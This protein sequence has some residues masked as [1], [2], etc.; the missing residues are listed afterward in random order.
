MREPSWSEAHP[1]LAKKI[2]E[3]ATPKHFP[4]C[5]P[6]E[7]VYNFMRDLGFRMSNWS[8]KHWERADGV[9]V[10]IYGAGSRARIYLK[11]QIATDCE[12][13]NLAQALN[14]EQRT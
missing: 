7:P 13:D 2:R 10:Q 6:R 4:V 1:E 3:A 12:L 14:T 5:G 9:Q 11:D 8:D